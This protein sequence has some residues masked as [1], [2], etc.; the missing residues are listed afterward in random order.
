MAWVWRNTAAYCAYKNDISNVEKYGYLYNWYAT[1]SGK[2]APSFGG[3]RI[4]TQAD[5]SKLL[6]FIGSYS[7]LK[8]SS[9]S[10]W[11]ENLNGTNDYGFNAI[12]SGGRFHA[13][14][15]FFSQRGIGAYFWTFSSSDIDSVYG[16]IVII[17]N[18]FSVALE[19][20]NSILSGLSV[21]LVRDK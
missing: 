14:Q 21:R 16:D 13:N 2:L 4:P 9:K 1:N 6:D 19:N 12:P 10:G 18:H 15:G 7:G 17:D 3:W 20:S 5:W 8:L 11:D